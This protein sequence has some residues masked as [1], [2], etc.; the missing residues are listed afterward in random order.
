MTENISTPTSTP[1]Y[2]V[3]TLENYL[4]MGT[5][6]SLAVITNGIMVFLITYHRKL[7]TRTNIIVLSLSLSN[8]GLAI[9]FLYPQFVVP[10]WPER[11]GLYCNVVEQMGFFFTISIS[12]HHCIISLDRAF[13]INFPI[14]YGL[15]SK[16]LHII[17]MLTVVWI[18]SIAIGFIPLFMLRLPSNNSCINPVVPDFISLLLYI[19]AY[20]CIILFCP[21]L[22]TIACYTNILFII[23]SPSRRQVYF[24]H[25]RV[26]RNKLVQNMKTT[27]QMIV[28]TGVYILAW[29]PYVTVHSIANIGYPEMAIKLFYSLIV[30]RYVAYSYV[31]VCPILHGHYIKAIRETWTKS[32][33]RGRNSKVKDSYYHTSSFLTANTSQRKQSLYSTKSDAAK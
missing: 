21:V 22:L 25:S 9:F 16:N 12:L 18:A 28:M 13:A 4:I 23:N 31:V 3:Y 20:W 2:R 5:I 19:R 14:R 17:I 29:S 24:R 8:I 7:R 33:V 6:A 26:S 11:L 15:Y 30:L 10:Y 1:W 32:L 27:S